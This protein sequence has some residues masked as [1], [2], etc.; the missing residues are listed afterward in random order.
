MKIRIVL[1]AAILLCGVAAFAQQQ[2]SIEHTAESCILSGEMP[3]MNVSTADNGVLRA[4][5]RR[6]GTA[7]WCSVDG[8]NLGKGSSVTLPS[9]ENGTD[10][11]YYFVVLRGKQVIAKSPEIYRT[12]AMTRCDSPIARHATIPVMECLPAGQNPVA[13]ALNAAYHASKEKPGK[14][15]VGSPERPE[16]Q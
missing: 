5:F 10:L 16:R 14:P 4:Y 3:I 11:E 2:G 9:F 15:P 6:L 12:K 13:D 7:D 8:K 1:S